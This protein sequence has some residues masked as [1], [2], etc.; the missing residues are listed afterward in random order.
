[1]KSSEEEGG[2]GVGVD[3]WFHKPAVGDIRQEEVIQ[4]DTRLSKDSRSLANMSLPFVEP[5]RH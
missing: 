5:D 3:G 1:M 4:L 2:G